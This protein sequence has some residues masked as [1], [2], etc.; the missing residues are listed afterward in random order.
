MTGLGVSKVEYRTVSQ[1]A[2]TSV[3]SRCAD[4]TLKTSW[5]RTKV[6]VE[7]LALL[8]RIRDVTGLILGSELACPD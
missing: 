4:S 7:R 1:C 5:I 6:M 3:A 8:L 2:K